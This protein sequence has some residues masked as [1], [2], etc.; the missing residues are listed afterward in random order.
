[1]ATNNIGTITQVT[2]AV[3]DVRFDADLP[4]ILNAVAKS[5]HKSPEEVAAG[6]TAAARSFFGL[7]QNTPAAESGYNHQQIS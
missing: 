5:M 7:A 2:G 6:T 4:H 3:V 1:M